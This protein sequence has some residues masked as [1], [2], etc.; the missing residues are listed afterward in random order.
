MKRIL[1]AVVGIALVVGSSLVVAAEFKVGV[2]NRSRILAE[3]APAKRAQ[4]KLEKEFKGRDD[5]LVKMSKR[6]KELQ[7]ALEKEGVTTSEGE[8]TKKE[9]ELATMDR[10]FQRAQRQFREDINLRQNEELVAI[11]ERTDK[12]IA[13]I[14]SQEKFDLI[15]FS[16][17][18]VFANPQL[19]V[20]DKVLKALAD[21]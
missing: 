16:E 20:T 1:A 5:E 15:L 8:R 11:M 2:I 12:V 3:S 19:D 10:D 4:T 18:A 7:V 6:A 17:Q 14:A 13:Q 9:R 21:K